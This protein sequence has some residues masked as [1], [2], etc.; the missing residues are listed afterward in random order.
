MSG[1][2]FPCARC[3]R[4][5]NA[6]RLPSCFGHFPLDYLPPSATGRSD[7]RRSPLHNTVC[8]TAG[9]AHVRACVRAYLRVTRRPGTKCDPTRKRAGHEV[10]ENDFFDK[11]IG[12]SDAA[13]GVNV[14]DSFCFCVV[15]FLFIVIIVF[16]DACDNDNRTAVRC[17]EGVG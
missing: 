10:I 14:D 15:C 7:G 13:D 4:R 16:K 8:S 12:G 1:V 9:R 3:G 11:R 17:A 2:G 5:R 6:F